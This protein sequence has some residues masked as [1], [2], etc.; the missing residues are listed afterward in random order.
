MRLIPD[1]NFESVVT[2]MTEALDDVETGE[3]TIATRSVEIDGVQVQEGQIIALHNG[4]LVLSAA[5]LEEACL[6]LLE[7]AHAD[8][9]ELITLFYGANVSKA[10]AFRIADVIRARFSNQE[11]EVQEG[12]QPHYQFIISIE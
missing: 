4:N 12:C 8:H 9:F 6:N 3:V 10:E 1:G 7:K 2:E 11:I 5:S